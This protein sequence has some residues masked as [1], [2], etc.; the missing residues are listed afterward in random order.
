MQIIHDSSTL[1]E[2]RRLLYESWNLCGD[3]KR[4]AN[5]KKTGKLRKNDIRNVRVSALFHDIGHLPFSHALE[6]LLEKETATLAYRAGISQI[7]KPH[8]YI[9]FRLLQTSYVREIV[10][11]FNE[12][13]K[14]ANPSFGIDLE[15][16]CNLVI[17]IRDKISSKDM[18]LLDV[19]HGETDA[20]R[21]DY[22]LRDSYYTGATHGEVDKERLFETFCIVSRGSALYLGIQEK[23][24]NRSKDSM[25]HEA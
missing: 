4:Q 12:K 5:Q 2:Q 24:W 21:I 6:P 15:L 8:E 18:F 11:K 19:I 7:G 20:D 17:G 3:N 23:V 16:I 25:P 10:G 13:A 1:S 14:A 9:T 22:L